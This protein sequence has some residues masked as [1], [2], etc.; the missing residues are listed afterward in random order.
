MQNVN[1]VPRH[2]AAER[3]EFYRNAMLRGI[4]RYGARTEAARALL[5]AETDRAAALAEQEASASSSPALSDAEAS[6]EPSEVQG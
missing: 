5:K 1:A 6:P 4:Q 3:A 2:N